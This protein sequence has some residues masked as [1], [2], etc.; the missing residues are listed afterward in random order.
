[1]SFYR[2]LWLGA[3]GA[4]AALAAVPSANAATSVFDVY[5]GGWNSAV[6]GT[7]YEYTCIPNTATGCGG[8]SEFTQ[9]NSI[10]LGGVTTINN[11]SSTIPLFANPVSVWGTF[12]PQDLKTGG[13]YTGDT[14]DS[15]YLDNNGA[16]VTSITLNLSPSMKSLGFVV[17]P[18]G[19][20][21]QPTVNQSFTVA[22]TGFG[23]DNTTT[24]Y[25][26]E[27]VSAGNTTVS[28]SV[29]GG[30]N[31][32]TFAGGNPAPDVCGFFGVNGG[33]T[34]S[35]T[36]SITDNTAGGFCSELQVFQQTDAI[37]SL[38]CDFPGI[39]IG[40]FVDTLSPIPEPTRSRCWVP[41]SS[42]WG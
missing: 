10:P 21:D 24:Y 37:S 13:T 23:G 16:P 18:E 22:V 38:S 29:T 35:L 42:G 11:P 28:C 32:G 36:I 41:A 39:G 40:D 1:M 31:A 7:I 34:S 5:N 26:K 2:S 6:G 4:V 30:T 14:W 3:L 19:I 9:V 27:K 17:L 20:G 25:E 12:W 33:S 8:S 15:N